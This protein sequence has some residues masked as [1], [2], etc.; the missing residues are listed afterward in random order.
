ML[1]TPALNTAFFVLAAI[2]GTCA[3]Q[4]FAN[5]DFT[6]TAANGAAPSSLDI[7]R[8]KF[9]AQYECGRSQWASLA[10]VPGTKPDRSTPGNPGSDIAAAPDPGTDVCPQD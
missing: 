1:R 5:G 7:T 10:A 3:A 2:V 4:V 6:A 9:V 8:R